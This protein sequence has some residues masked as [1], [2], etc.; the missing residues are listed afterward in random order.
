MIT[1]LNNYRAVFMLPKWLRSA[2]F[3]ITVDTCQQPSFINWLPSVDL[4][5]RIP[6]RAFPMKYSRRYIRTECAHKPP[7]VYHPK[8]VYRQ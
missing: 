7:K 4:A 2:R 1:P 6:A 5:R 8:L 3:R